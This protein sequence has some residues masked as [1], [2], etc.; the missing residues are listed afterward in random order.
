MKG[1]KEISSAD[2]RLLTV[3]VDVNALAM[4]GAINACSKRAKDDPCQR[5]HS[6]RDA[7]HIKSVP[8]PKKSDQKSIFQLG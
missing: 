1:K 2:R 7:S 6:I 4:T 3:H 5:S 8:I